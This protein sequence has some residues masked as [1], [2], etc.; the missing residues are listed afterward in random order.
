MLAFALRRAI[1]AIPTLFGVSL[2][3]FLLTTLLPDP[4]PTP[5]GVPGDVGYRLQGRRPPP[6]AFSRPAALRQRRAARRADRRRRLRRAHRR[7]TTTTPSSA[8]S[9]SSQIGGAGLPYLLPHLDNVPPEPRGQHR[10]RACPGRA[11]H[12][13]GRGTRP[14][15]TPDRA[16]LFW[17][18][19]WEDRSVDFTAPAVRREVDRLVQRG[20]DLRE[21][22]LRIGRH[23]RPRAAHRG[24]AGHEGPRR[25]RPP[26]APRVARH[27][28][29][30]RREAR[31][32]RQA[33]ARAVVSDWQSWWYVHESDY[34]ALQ[35][36]AKVDREHRAD[37]LREMGAR[38]R[39]GSARPL[40][41]R[42]RAGLR[43]APRARARDARHG[44]PRA[45]PQRCRS[46]SRSA[47]SPRG[48]AGTPSITSRRSSSS[49]S[50]RCRRSS[51]PSCSR[52]SFAL[53]TPRFVLPVVALAT[54]SL[55]VM[56][57]QQRA[58]MIE[59]LYQD[60]IRA[61]R[62]KGARTLRVAVDHALRNAL[63]P[64][65]TLAGVQFPALVGAAFVVEEV[66]G[67][68]GMGWETLRAIESRDAAWI[69]AVTLL[70]AVVTTACL[71]GERR[72]VR[73]ARPAG[74]RAADPSEARH[75]SDV[76]NDP[77]SRENN[78]ESIPLLL[79]R[80]TGRIPLAGRKSQQ[81]P[82]PR[83]RLSIR[84]QSTR[85]ETA[86]TIGY[87]RS[88]LGAAGTLVAV[89]LVLFAIFADMLASDLPIACKLHGHV[90]L[91][92]NVTQPAELV[93]LGGEEIAL[94]GGLDDQPGRRARPGRRRP[95]RHRGAAATARSREGPSV[96]HRPRRPRRVRARRARNAHVP[97]VRARRRHRVAAL[98]RRAGRARG[99][100]RRR[101]RTRSSAERSRR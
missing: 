52:R 16:A 97:R 65:V 77:E 36:G 27:R 60:Y 89:F 86:G 7:R 64:T 44:V 6:S 90:W 58:S 50:I 15:P 22:E 46:R 92:P 57:Q 70:C 96:R 2:V 25:A 14:R 9:A 13:R 55:S 88:R 95:G 54:V 71:V 66:F 80:T 47:C 101:R 79:A 74:A 82:A 76:P 81:P 4:E 19:F 23:V 43:Q 78:R 5:G 94:A 20:T 67:I 93:A 100:L 48:G 12:G 35:G 33:R 42:R 56:T 72:R 49:R 31:G 32:R 3:V 17:E 99:A 75:M 61:A 37:A 26:D 98:R 53:P 41:A 51:S 24:D 68:H 39:D 40:D 10:A 84:F 87:L 1:W 8:R 69:V 59:A 38:R 45:P 21:E 34:V 30:R 18:R 29:R 63:V 91:F 28:S 11:T 62:A 83:P 73:S 85:K